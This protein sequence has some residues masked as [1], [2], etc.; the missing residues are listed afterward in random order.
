MS[1][2]ADFIHKEGFGNLFVNEKREGDQPN[3]R[4]SFTVPFDC[5]A[6]DV[7]EIAAWTGKT[8]EDKKMLSLKFQ[9]PYVKAENNAEPSRPKTPFED[10]DSDCPF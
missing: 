6:G 10:M 9:K 5:K 1:K 8:R 7:M 4:G 2:M 3:M